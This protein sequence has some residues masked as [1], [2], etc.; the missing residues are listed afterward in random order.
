MNRWDFNLRKYD[1]KCEN[2]IEP[3]G[4]KFV[5]DAKNTYGYGDSYLKVEKSINNLNKLNKNDNKSNLSEENTKIL[6]KMA[7]NICINS[8]KGLAMNLFVM[9]MSGGASGIFGIIFIIYSIY[10]ILK[11]LFNINDVFK[12]V[13]NNTKQKFWLQKICFIIVNCSVFI[14]IMNVCSKSGLL[15]IRS[16]DYFYY[17]PHKKIKQKGVGSFF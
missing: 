6:N 12:S 2:L 5:N 16:G 4:Y 10:N 3:F 17:I 14:Y 9:F 7:W 11:S 15:P 13:E 1:Q 8:I